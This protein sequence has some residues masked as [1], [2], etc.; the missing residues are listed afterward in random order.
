MKLSVEAWDFYV[1]QAIKVFALHGSDTVTLLFKYIIC[2]LYEWLKVNCIMFCVIMSV[3]CQ[4]C[5][6]LFVGRSS[7]IYGLV[8]V[9]R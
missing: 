3:R 4:I 7:N 6:I 9:C 8:T 2:V 1:P 5:M